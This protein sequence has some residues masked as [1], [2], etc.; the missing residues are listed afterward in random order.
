MSNYKNSVQIF[1][2]GV[3]ELDQRIDNYLF[4]SLKYIPKSKIYSLLRKGGIRVNGRHV[5]HIYRLK[6]NDVI[7]V[8][9]LWYFNKNNNIVKYFNNKF[10]MLLQRSILYEDEDLLIIN[11]PS[12]IA[13]HD[14]TRL[15]NNILDGLR[16]LY[17][18]NVFLEL[19]HR[20]DRDTSGLLL[21]AKNRYSLCCLHRQFRNY[22]IK[23]KYL[24]LVYGKWPIDLK[25][26]DIPVIHKKICINSIK[27]KF[28]SINIKYSETH[29]S[30]KRYFKFSTLIRAKLITGKTHQIRLHTSYLGHCIAFDK[31][32]GKFKFDNQLVH[33]GLKRLFLHAYELKFIHPRTNKTILIRAPLDKDLKICLDN[34]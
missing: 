7:R 19:V 18:Y 29:F 16:F 9:S 1:T 6:I 4:K 27:N 14:G 28:S 15:S 32:Y 33:T 25:I 21:L 24:A 10:I 2:I 34:L 11:K 20:I 8:S 23:K 3:N 13:V 12:G 22:Q 31:L 5:K 17:S 30:V 26:V